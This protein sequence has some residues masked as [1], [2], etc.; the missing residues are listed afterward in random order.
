MP[1]SALQPI[2]LQALER[3]KLSLAKRILNHLI[4]RSY[5]IA[6]SQHPARQFRKLKEG[7]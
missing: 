4:G 7:L 2:A 6:A 1:D 5:E 3:V